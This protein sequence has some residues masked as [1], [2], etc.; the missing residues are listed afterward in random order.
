[1]EEE[2]QLV[3]AEWGLSEVVYEDSIDYYLDNEHWT[4]DQFDDYWENGGEDKEIDNYVATTVDNYDDST[5][6]GLGTL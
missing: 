3:I 5:W 6:E 1:G 4:Q 2:K